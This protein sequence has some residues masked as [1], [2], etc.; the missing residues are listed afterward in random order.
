MRKLFVIAA[1]LLLICTTLA[2]NVSAEKNLNR[3]SSYQA[4]A[5]KVH[6]IVQESVKEWKES[7][8]AQ[9]DKAA[10][11]LED[12]YLATFQKTGEDIEVYQN[13]YLTRLQET[14]KTL[15]NEDFSEFERAKKEE[16]NAEISEDVGL[17]LEDLLTETN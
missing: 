15:L 4:Y 5:E 14:K 12:F 1:A 10:K 3:E 11:G 13:G 9:I 6:I 7:W 2:V 17:F 8:D 16:I